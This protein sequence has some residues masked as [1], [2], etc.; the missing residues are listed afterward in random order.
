VAD[1]FDTLA[2]SAE[3]RVPTIVLHGDADEIVPFWMG[4]RVAGAI[5]GAR[6]LR[7]PGGHH[8]DLFGHD[9]ERL[10]TE[11]VGSGT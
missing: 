7:V 8:G 10:L 9:A 6:L 2:K 3:I 11:L 5:P 4:Q 1:H